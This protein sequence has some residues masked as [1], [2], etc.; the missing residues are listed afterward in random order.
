MKPQLKAP[1]TAVPPADMAAVLGQSHW[2]TA[3][4]ALLAVRITQGFIYWGG[5]SRRFL[6]DG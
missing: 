5:G 1:G 6:Y 4:I 3:A 2:R